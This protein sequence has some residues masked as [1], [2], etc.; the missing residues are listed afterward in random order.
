MKPSRFTILKLLRRREL[1]ASPAQAPLRRQNA[2]H[3]RT[4]EFTALDENN[5]GVLDRSEAASSPALAA[6]FKEADLDGDGQLSRFEYL[7][8]M[9]Q[10]SR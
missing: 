7:K 6:R 5:D 8:A 1:H 3:R 2:L 10:S 9:G 4:P